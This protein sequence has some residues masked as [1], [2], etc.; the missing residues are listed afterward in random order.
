M[1]IATPWS[2][3]FSQESQVPA[4]PF[5]AETT[6]N[7]R[8]RLGPGTDFLTITTLSRGTVVIVTD[9]PPSRY[10]WVMIQWD[11]QQTGWVH[12]KYLRRTSKST[13][14][15]STTDI[16]A[17][18]NK[19]KNI[20][21]Y[22]WTGIGHVA[23][24]LFII[25]FIVG[26]WDKIFGA[27]VSLGILGAYL[28]K[29]SYA[30]TSF[31]FFVSNTLQ[32]YLAKPWIIFFHNNHFSDQTN[33]ILRQIFQW[34]KVPL[35]ILLTPLRI[36]NAVFFNIFIHCIFELFNY[37]LEVAVPTR[38]DEGEYSIWEWFLYLPKRICKY[39]LY[40]PLLTII[41]SIIWTIVDIFLPALTL[42]HGTSPN[43][44][45]SIVSS[46]ERIG[47]FSSTTGIWNVG[48]GNFA[49]NGIYFA[50]A[51]STSKH[52]SSG[53]M[54]I[55]RVTLGHTLDLGL[56]PHYVFYQCGH[57]NAYGVT[58]W[59]LKNGYVSGEWW[60]SDTHWWEYCMYDWQNRYNYS[61]RIRPLYIVDLENGFLQRIP[62]GMSHWLFRK[63]ILQDI[64][65]SFKNFYS[66]YLRKE[67]YF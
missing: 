45:E 19:P 9:N 63:M 7:L 62:C 4:T 58:D 41:E 59:G 34:V 29:W 24:A 57:A 52:Y 51:R 5:N 66:L 53:S 65:T 67:K 39:G 40:H 47:S 43:A 16:D 20:R 15:V 10:P 55:C 14:F 11:K 30:L 6:S 56:A 37:I 18:K 17:K 49:G 27:A 22:I 32:R 38:Y 23:L 36:I 64:R 46:P 60:R 2:C 26:V 13:S 44:A 35:Y 8:V 48:R 21:Q 25:F 42:Y 1:G 50:P 28:I 3:V 61:W 54:I 33:R 31:P 12:S